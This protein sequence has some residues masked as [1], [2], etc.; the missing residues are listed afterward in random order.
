[1][2]ISHIK[3]FFLV[4][5]RWKDISEQAWHDIKT[6][7]FP[8]P[9]DILFAT[10][11]TKKPYFED[12]MKRCGRY[13]MSLNLSTPC[14]SFIYSVRDH[15]HNLTKL[16]LEFTKCYYR[17]FW[18]AFSS[19]EK[20]EIFE[21]TN[22]KPE[23]IGDCLGTLPET[24]KKIHMSMASSKHIFDFSDKFL[25]RNTPFVS[26]IFLIGHQIKLFSYK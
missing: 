10:Q 7:T 8:N 14:S 2:F 3:F 20:L 25:P 18:D 12:L 19:M 13:L 21:I 5:T 4:C 23:F 15:C 17:H 26:I 24:I 11:K 9:E 22:I 16:K 1:M 6:L